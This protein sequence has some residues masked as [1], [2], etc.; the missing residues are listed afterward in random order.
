[1]SKVILI[2]LDG[3]GH[4]EQKEHNA[5]YLASPKHYESFLKNYPH[6]L[7]M[8]SGEAVG[9]PHGVMGNSEVGHLS[10][11]SGR[12]ILQEFTRIS[13][14]AE[15][16]GFESL[17]DFKR[18]VE[19]P[20]GALHFIGLVSD[21]GVH[22]DVNHLYKM[23]ESVERT[24][25]TKPV[26]IHVITDGRDTAP[27]SACRYVEE[28]TKRISVVPNVKIATVIGR[29]YAMDRDKRWERVE[30][31]YRALTETLGPEYSNAEDAIAEAYAQGETDE[32]IKPRRM[33]NTSRIRSDDQVV[34]FN[35]RADRAREISS[36]FAIQS[37]KEFQTSVKIK[38]E[39]WI[40][41]SRYSEDFPFPYL[42]HPQKY[43]RLLGELVAEKGFKQLRIA[44]TEKYAHVTYFF[45]GGEE[46]AYAG[47]DRVLIPSPKD[48]ATY[49]LKPEMSARQITD[50]LVKR[51]ESEKYQFIA[52]NYANGDMVGHTGN[53]AA[54]IEAVKVIDE[55]LGRIAAAALPKGYE[56]VLSSD[57]GNVEQMIDPATGGPLTAHSM[58]PVPFV[59]IGERAKGRKLKNGA[60]ADIAPTILKLFGWDQPPEMRGK[61]L[62]E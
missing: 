3:F 13:K 25:K 57:H 62:I 19:N 18:V 59:W 54:S 30:T 38:P 61:S 24:N 51:I 6:S 21:G 12:V 23:I 22:S 34:F 40:T 49:D 45:N 32:F 42:F 44:E 5:I 35:F 2:I 43:K 20:H 47:E 33:I 7:L 58:N 53:E 41:F 48:V 37:F 15:D 4:S 39:N 17:P 60:L 10:I 9:L 28:L 56:I 29:F 50:E 11:G 16:N 8:T 36:A 55:C 46:T 27:D 31:A 26:Y 14:F 52:V 1:M